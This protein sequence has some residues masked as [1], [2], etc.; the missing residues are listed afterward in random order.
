[1][2][3]PLDLLLDKRRQGHISPTKCWHSVRCSNPG[4][5]AASY[6]PHT[7][8]HTGLAF[9]RAGHLNTTAV[10]PHLASN[11][12]ASECCLPSAESSPLKPCP[13][14]CPLSPS[15]YIGRSYVISQVQRDHN[16][17]RAWPAPQV[18]AHLHTTQVNRHAA[19]DFS[20]KLLCLRAT[21]EG[22]KG[23]ASSGLPS[24]STGAQ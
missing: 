5:C 17:R 14:Q 23:L 13:S 3:C 1:M 21:L 8:T 2:V 18:G 22:E 11:L 6:S 19:L 12:L 16:K 20:G 7:H 24:S 9:R 10:L 15:V 4:Q